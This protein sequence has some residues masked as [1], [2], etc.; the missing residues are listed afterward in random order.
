MR[1]RTVQSVLARRHMFKNGGMV[2]PQAQPA[3]ILAS[4]PSLVDAVSNDAL[5][6][7]GGGTLSMAQGGAAVNM[8]P[9]YVFNQGGV[10]KF[11]PGGVV[12]VPLNPMI[13]QPTYSEELLDNRSVV[14]I[15]KD[16]GDFLFKAM[17]ERNR[18]MEPFKKEGDF[19]SRMYDKFYAPA[20]LEGERAQARTDKEKE[21]QAGMTEIEEMPITVFLSQ[22]G[23]PD[24]VIKY[25]SETGNLPVGYREAFEKAQGGG[26]IEGYVRASPARGSGKAVA[27]SIA[28]PTDKNIPGESDFDSGMGN[29]GLTQDYLDEQRLIEEDKLRQGYLG[30]DYIAGMGAVGKSGPLQDQEAGVADDVDESGFYGD[31]IPSPQSVVS[32]TEDE[33][34]VPGTVSD[35]K[36][37]DMQG[38]LPP[39][40]KP[41][42]PE[43][44]TTDGFGE[45]GTEYDESVDPVAANVTK[46]FEEKKVDETG[47]ERPKTKEEFIQ[48]F[49]ESMPKYEGMSEEEKGFTIMEAGLRV[50][51]GKSPNAVENIAEG[52]K[53]VSKEFVKDKK[54][55]RAFEQQVDLSA[56]KYALTGMTKLRAEEIAL[57]KEGRKR[58][59]Q[60]IANKDFTVNGQ[61][62]KKGTAV[63]LTEN[64][65]RNGWLER[66]PITYKE[67]F[68]SEAKAAAAA[69]EKNTKDLIKPPQFSDSRK[70]YLTAASS[71]KNSL[72]MKGLLME[73]A[74]I[75]VPESGQDS[76]VL[77]AVP[78]FKTWV[79]KALNAAGYQQDA[80]GRGKLN[81]L[82]SGKPDEYRT[83]MKTIGTTMVTEILNESNKTISEGDRARVDELV[84]AYTDYDGTV[85]SHR[86]LLLKLKNLE[87]TIDK[88]LSDANDS[89]TALEGQWGNARL[90]GGGDPQQIFSRIRNPSQSFSY[91]VGERS[92]KP[93]YYKDIINMKTRTFTPKFKSVFG[94]RSK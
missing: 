26:T 76:Q 33:S 55:K 85:A 87:K 69:A 18:Q 3:G 47:Q 48:D 4:S 9:S 39:K 40:I 93:I 77:G 63:P 41:S 12:R 27:T 35:K 44:L 88:G 46:I 28:L 37:T 25:Y 13:P 7:M 62:I 65:I 64:Q 20:R 53:G 54:A 71:V 22:I 90:V 82:R 57:A 32:G 94:K 36:V 42:A 72:R 16:R 38:I 60:L 84:A 51:A 79:N 34:V 52:L 74:K 43:K 10:A 29:A 91:N 67:T 31:S 17:Q 50:M 66:F 2:P 89:M 30:S 59:F 1:K 45:F 56:A 58:P 49:K 8:Q 80:K 83:L 68:L 24:D 70:A 5:S 11:A 92:S 75:A 86:S 6:D 61:L 15:A 81:E 73:A 78:L 21:R 19:L 14:D 23:A